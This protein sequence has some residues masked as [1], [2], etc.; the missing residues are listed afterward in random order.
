[1][2]GEAA[3]SCQYSITFCCHT[4]DSSRGADWPN[5]MW[6][7]STCET[8][9]WQLIPSHRKKNGTHWH[10]HWHLLNFYGDQTVDVSRVR[11]CVVQFS[12]GTRNMKDKPCS[13]WPCTAVTTW[14]E[15]HLDQFICANLL[16]VVTVEKQCFVALSNIVIV[17]FVSFAVFMEK[18]EELLLEWPT[19]SAHLYSFFWSNKTKDWG[20][21]EKC[22]Y[23]AKG[24]R[25]FSLKPADKQLASVFNQYHLG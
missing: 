7:G 5:S 1:M 24:K 13:S 12:S 9:V 16:M 21:E 25:T 23:Y 3:P 10:I 19:H 22:K 2:A 6:H 14:N 11:Q 18:W 8:K 4:T 20:K 15:E 17:L